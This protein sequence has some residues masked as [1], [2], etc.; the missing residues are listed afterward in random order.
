MRPSLEVYAQESKQV[1]A[2]PL[3]PSVTLQENGPYAS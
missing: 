2:G 1:V 3:T